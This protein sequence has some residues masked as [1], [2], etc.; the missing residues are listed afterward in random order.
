VTPDC[1]QDLLAGITRASIIELVTSELGMQVVERSVNR[2]ELYCADEVFLCGTAAEV[3]PVIAIDNRPVAEG[4][5]GVVTK[6]VRDLYAD[7]VRGKNEV[8]MRWC[9]PIYGPEGNEPIG[10]PVALKVEPTS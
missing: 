9:R 2:G 4:R 8:R 3:T 5:V 7:A 1:G 6:A 10:V